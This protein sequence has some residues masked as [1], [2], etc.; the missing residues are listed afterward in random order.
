MKPSP[1]PCLSSNHKRGISASLSLLDQR[2]CEVERCAKLREW[3]SVL[4]KQENALTIEQSRE[5]FSQLSGIRAI[6]TQVRD[7]LELEPK[8]ECLAWS[9]QACCAALLQNLGE[10][11]EK[12]LRRYGPVPASLVEYLKPRLTELTERLQRISAVVGEASRNGPT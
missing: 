2:I 10:L 7:D 3:R 11:D 8:I 1:R 6:L 9:I 5:I 12:H 4:Y